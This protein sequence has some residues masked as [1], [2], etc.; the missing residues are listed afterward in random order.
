MFLILFECSSYSFRYML[1]IKGF[2]LQKKCIM[3]TQQIVY[4]KR[5]FEVES[6]TLHSRD[7][8]VLLGGDRF[9]LACQLL[10]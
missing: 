3:F 1:N 4:T 10:M 2:F 9:F 8:H 7:Q 6:M 5:F